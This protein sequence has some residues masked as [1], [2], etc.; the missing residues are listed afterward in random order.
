MLNEDK[1][2]LLTFGN[3]SDDS[4]S[5][6]VDSSTIANIAEEKLLGVTL[7]SKLTFEHHVRNLCQ[8]V[9]NKLFALSRIA[10]CMD[11][12]K[13]RMLMTSYINSQFQYCP[14]A[15]MFHSRKLNTKINKLHE[16]SLRITH[17]DQ[18]SSFEN[19]LGYDNSVSVHQENLQVVMIE[20]FK[21]KHGLNPPFMKEIFC[22]QTS[23]TSEMIVILI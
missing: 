8:K 21:T 22:P 3:M 1:C 10:H 17:R 15:W 9:S 11:Q 4:V 23:I 20:M 13:L 5:I 7:D 6:K 16:R 19:L 12:A 14:L 18:E 2:Y